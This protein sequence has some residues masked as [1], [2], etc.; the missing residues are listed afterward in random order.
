MTSTSL[1]VSVSASVSLSTSLSVSVST[2]VS[3]LSKFSIDTENV[4]VLGSRKNFEKKFLME[5]RT[6]GDE[7]RK[8][9]N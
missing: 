4:S 8:L 7:T 2:S 1:S 5:N 9:Y 6:D 3:L